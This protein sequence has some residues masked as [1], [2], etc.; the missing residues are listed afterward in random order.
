MFNYY[1]R[2][3]NAYDLA[4]MGH[5]TYVRSVQSKYMFGI[6]VLDT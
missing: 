6:D 3:V 5:I 1:M 2:M 4:P